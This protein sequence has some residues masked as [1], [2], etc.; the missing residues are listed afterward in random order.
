MGTPHHG[1]QS[2]QEWLV[3]LRPQLDCQKC[4]M[5][6]YTIKQTENHSHVRAV[7]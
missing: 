4:H 5:C 1:T 3:I 2:C 6:C 7:L